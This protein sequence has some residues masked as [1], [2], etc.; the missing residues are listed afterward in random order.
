MKSLFLSIGYVKE[1]HRIPSFLPDTPSERKRPAP[2][3]HK[4]GAGP[5]LDP[6]F[7]LNR[8]EASSERWVSRPAG[9]RAPGKGVVPMKRNERETFYWLVIGTLL[10]IVLLLLIK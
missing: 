1:L 4:L 10:V 5:F 7:C 9:Q 8:F 6:V 3:S 2:E